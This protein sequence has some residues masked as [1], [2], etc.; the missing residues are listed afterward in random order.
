[1]TK[2]VVCQRKPPCH[3]DVDDRAED[4]EDNELEQAAPHDN[5]LRHIF[6]S[7]AAFGTTGGEVAAQ[8]VAAVD[9][10]TAFAADDSAR[11]DR[12]KCYYPKQR[13]VE[14]CVDRQSGPDGEDGEWPGIGDLPCAPLK[15]HRNGGDRV[16]GL[17][18]PAK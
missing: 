12:A 11:S 2:L 13:S 9:A 17:I 1:M 16:P 18:L 8:V 5:I 15:A 4:E 14:D 10:A 3:G 7:P 6:P